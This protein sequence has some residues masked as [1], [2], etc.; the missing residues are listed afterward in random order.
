M[1][2]RLHSQVICIIIPPPRTHT[3]PQCADI[4]FI[5]IQILC[6]R[7]LLS[8]VNY[9]FW[10]NIT[11]M[12]SAFFFSFFYSET[13]RGYGE[14]VSVSKRQLWIS[15]EDA[16]LWTFAGLISY[17]HCRLPLACAPIRYSE[18]FSDAVQHS[19]CVFFFFFYILHRVCFSSFW[20]KH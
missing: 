15:T 9:L 17:Q 18:V 3:S 12:F 2:T 4:E 19:C 1:S 16:Q 6:Q 8:S 13:H 5:S 20:S 14:V 7:T 11:I 10:K